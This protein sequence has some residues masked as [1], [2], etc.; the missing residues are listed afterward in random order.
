MIF[1]LTI[2]SLYWSSV[3]VSYQQ[4]DRVQQCTSS[5]IV[6][7]FSLLLR[8]VVWNGFVYNPEVLFA[9]PLLRRVLP[10]VPC[11]K[12]EVPVYC[13]QIDPK[14]CVFVW[15][16][17]CFF[18]LLSSHFFWKFILETRYIYMIPLGFF[19]RIYRIYSP[20][21]VRFHIFWVE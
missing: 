9:Q 21:N 14:I 15:A 16:S 1:L 7:T 13:R 6:M 5:D 4:R 17:A 12:T 11:H 18:S 10:N 8:M 3:S 19:G 2:G 20:L